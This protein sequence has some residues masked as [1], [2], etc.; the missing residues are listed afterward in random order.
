MTLV[1]SVLMAPGVIYLSWRYYVVTRYLF[2]SGNWP[3][4]ILLS[5]LS[6]FYLFPASML[7]SYFLDGEIDVLAFSHI[8]D[9]WFWLGLIFVYALA[10]WVIIADV[11]KLLSRWVTDKRTLISQIHAWGILLLFVIVFFYTGFKTYKDTTQIRIEKTDLHFKDLPASLDG[12]KIVHISDIH[13]DEYTGKKKI[14]RYIRKVNQQQPDLIIFTGDLISYGNDYIRMAAR[15]LGKA[16]AT[17][18]TISVV[19]DHDYWAGVQNV[20]DALDEQGIPMVRDSNYKVTIDSTTQALVTGVTQVYSKKVPPAVADS[21]SRYSGPAAIKIF[22]THQVAD[23]LIKDAQR[24]H[25]D[26]MLAGHTHGG[27]LW[28]PFMGM[29]F[30]PSNLETDYVR[31]VYHLGKLVLNVNSGLG[32]TLAPIRYDAPAN[33]SVIRLRTE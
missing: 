26:L 20:E 25:Y 14:A 15:E 6:S 7:I 2:P 5:F 13:A 21:L 9:Y 18:G 23:H 27:Q 8:L 22:A 31:G 33:I 4:Y 32:F 12:F 10:S 24:S 17:Y 16:K 11:I 29:S 28:V 3:K 1:V 30:S 19:G